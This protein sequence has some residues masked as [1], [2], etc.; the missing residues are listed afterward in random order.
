MPIDGLTDIKLRTHLINYLQDWVLL[1]L[2]QIE[3]L[4]IYPM[5]IFFKFLNSPFYMI[6]LNLKFQ[7]QQ[8]EVYWEMQI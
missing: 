8:M 6:I 5:G 2:F 3:A 1:T 7:T 4:F